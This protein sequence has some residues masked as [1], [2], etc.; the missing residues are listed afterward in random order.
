MVRKLCR[1]IVITC[2]L[3]SSGCCNYWLDQ[4]ANSKTSDEEHHAMI[5]LKLS[6]I[7]YE[8]HFGEA[9]GTIAPDYD[10]DV[11]SPEYPYAYVRCPLT[12]KKI[13]HKLVDPERNG[14]MLYLRQ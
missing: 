7:D 5:M 8:Y 10:Y 4:L 11:W 9:D 2:L 1:F 6:H 3:M 13:I 12:G 14:W